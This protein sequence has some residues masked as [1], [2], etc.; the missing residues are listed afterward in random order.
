VS[1]AETAHTTDAEAR[2]LHAVLDQARETLFIS[3]NGTPEDLQRSLGKLN[4]ACKAHW[5]WRVEK[6]LNG[7]DGT[8][9]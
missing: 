7:E 2:L 4:L 1:K 6:L 3:I 8:K 5:D 9:P